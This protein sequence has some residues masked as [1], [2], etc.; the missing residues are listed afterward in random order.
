MTFHAR[1]TAH[2]AERAKLVAAV[3]PEARKDTAEA[4]AAGK[5]DLAVHHH[6]DYARALA[7]LRAGDHERQ[8]QRRARQ[9]RD[10]LQD[11]RLD[12]AIDAQPHAFSSGGATAGEP[13]AKP[14]LTQ[15]G[16]SHL[17]SQMKA[18]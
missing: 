8:A 11:A 17:S 12:R 14:S 1:N 16:G 15:A 2:F 10:A 6:R 4:F 5:L 13:P 3:L 7:G 9:N 18:A